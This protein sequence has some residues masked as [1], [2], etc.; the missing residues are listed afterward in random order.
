MTQSNAELLEPIPGAN[1]SGTYL[2]YD[3]LYDQI[4]EARREDDDLPQGDWATSRKVA[5]W[6]L[7]VR[8]TTDALKKKTKDLQIAAWLAEAWLKREGVAGLR[9]GIDL[10][11]ELVQR[12]WDT[13][14]PEIDDGDAEMRAAP[15]EW[16]GLKFD[17][18]VRLA[19]LTQDGYSLIDLRVSRTVPT[20]EQADEDSDRA[21]EREAAIEDG[22]ITPEEFERSFTATPKAWYRELATEIDAA[23]AA[24]DA[25]DASCTERFED[26]RPGFGPLRSALQDVKQAAG[27]LLSRKLELE[28]DPPTET[29]AELESAPAADGT[30]AGD[31]AGAAEAGGRTVSLS[32]GPKDRDE[33]AQWV[34]A[35]ARKLRQEQPTDPAPYL[36][37]RGLRWGELRAGGSRIDP[38]LLAAPPTEVRTRLKTMLLDAN[39]PQL[40]N[41]AEEVMAQ[42]YG[43]GWIDLQR[44]VLTAVDGLGGEY[45]AVGTAIRGTLR[46]LLADLPDLLGQT[47]M[48]DSPTAN[49]ETMNWLADEKLLPDGGE[50]PV[51]TAPV[52]RRS[53]A[54]RRDAWEI[55]KARVGAGDARGAMELLMREATQE[56]SARARFMRRA[57]AA[58]VMVGAGMEPVAM[59][60][61]REL[62]E[63]V[64]THRLD[65]WEAGDTV[66]QPLALLY[67]CATR[68]SSGE[69][70]A[71]SLYERICRL[72]PV[73]AIQLRP[74][75]DSDDGGG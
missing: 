73:R 20:K 10:L 4:K 60:I 35:A 3:P 7:V 47:L 39:W 8:L 25:L 53:S 23:Q 22:K 12:Y 38:R 44:Y 65:E 59:P 17:L 43:R 50:Q 34:A 74:S 55:A 69:V 45:E 70:D 64:E 51:D 46:T 27:Q 9:R 72:D 71:E 54:S 68:L 37:L 62:L 5:D 58:E 75:R 19:P 29:I 66:A 6:P 57:Q 24:L 30:G 13:V 40:L 1:P 36:M 33:A 26:L 48:D 2:R 41:A 15:L 67:R 61:L 56:K 52:E 32:A 16:V 18:P 28:P 11:H 21:A 63:Q 49:A 42:P 31:T 14:H